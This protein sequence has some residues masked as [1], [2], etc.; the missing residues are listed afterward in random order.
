MN[1]EYWLQR[2]RE[3]RTGWHHDKVMPL[4]EK[5]WP[6]LNVPRGA[7]VLVPLCG[8]SLDMLWLAQQGLQ[9]LGVDLSPVALETFLT[10]NQLHARGRAQAG[11]THYEVTNPPGGGIEL[12]NGDVFSVAGAVLGACHAFYDRAALIALPAADR[13]RL[14]GEV[15]ATLA[16]AAR[17]LLITLDY[18]EGEMQ[19]PPFSVDESEVHRLFD[20][21]WTVRQLER[22]DIL[23]SQPSFRD[24][25]VSALH[26]AVYALLRAAG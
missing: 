3:G 7:R 16:P 8:K 14:A 19:G 17:G 11:S 18:P 9:V 6:T 26:T 5:H 4:L 25:G 10:D 20:A 24:N 21:R 2:W 1:A 15:Y 22:R 23:A 13:E 12:V